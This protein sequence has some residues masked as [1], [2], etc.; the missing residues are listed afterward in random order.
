MLIS[1]KVFNQVPVMHTHEGSLLKSLK[2]M[3]RSLW[4]LR[5]L[6]LVCII[7]NVVVMTK[8]LNYLISHSYCRC[9]LKKEQFISGSMFFT[10]E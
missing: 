5:L 2:D 9:L 1:E 8:E 10:K 7:E 3:L 6:I 4:F